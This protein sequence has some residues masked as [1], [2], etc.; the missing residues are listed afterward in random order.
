MPRFFASFSET[1]GAARLD[2]EEMHHARDVMRMKPGE[3]MTLIIDDR[4]F[5]SAFSP[6]GDFPLLSELPST[7]PS[8]RVTLYQGVPK[9]DKMDFITQ[10]CVEAGVYAIV[11]VAFSRCVSRW[12]KGKDEEKKR[13]RY[14]RIAREAA[15]QSGRA[16]CPQVMPCLSFQEMLRALPA[17]GAALAPWEC[18][19][20]GGL[21][22]FVE[23]SG[24]P[25]DVALVIGPEGGISEKEM[26]AM[27][28]AGALPVTLGK[29]ILRTETAGLAAL[30][31]LMALS[32]NME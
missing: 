13:A 23:K 19:G 9:G 26:A 5:L 6:S 22:T 3:E 10:K 12:E 16:H 28:Q 14:N 11:P 17:H 30:V 18:A 20:S 29:R 31:A 32:G 4:L 7:E 1:A 24:L 21:K 25:R 8:V 27:A 15:K 2:E